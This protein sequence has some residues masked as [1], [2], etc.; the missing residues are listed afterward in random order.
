MAPRG[1]LVVGVDCSTTACKAILWNERGRALAEGRAPVAL[2]NPAPDAYEQDAEA[3]W[4]ATRLAL[5]RAL[6]AAGPRAPSRLDAICVTHQRE[7]VVVT[8]DEGRPLAPALVWMDARC[9]PQVRR[10]REALGED[11]LHQVSGKVPCTTPS[12]YKLMGL[13]ER[14]PSLDPARLRALEVHAFLAYRLTG[15]LATS[16]ASADPTGLVD[17]RRGAW[18]EGIARLAGLDPSRL[19]EL[20]PPGALLGP[21]QPRAARALGLPE[22]LPVVAGAGDGQAAALGAG[23][24]GPE[25]A[26]LNLGTA[27]V[28]GV[29]SPSY[30]V[31]RAFRTLYTAHPGAYLLETDLKGGTFSLGWFAGNVLGRRG[32]RTLERLRALEREARAQPPA[33]GGLLFVPYLHGVMNPYWDDDASALWFGLR[34][35]HDA[36]SLYRSLL[37]GLAFEQRLALE[38][39]EKETGQGV[40]EL[41]VMGGGTKSELFCQIV[42]D[43]TQKPLRLT[44]SAEATCLGAGMLAAVAAGWFGGAAEAARAMSSSGRVVTPG[45][46][47][48]AYDA[49]FRRVYA[50]LYPALERAAAEAAK[51]RTPD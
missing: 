4:R 50:G 9:R 19:P 38:G 36:A 23:V 15:R 21:L 28:C 32:A 14:E 31:G 17:M 8:D 20:V 44:G 37:E 25:S 7:T 13:F 29:P 47:R 24:T 22:G 35:D 45:P 41:R 48:S 33:S 6:A 30:R 18:A 12:V 16:L 11:E 5:R 2:S 42:A 43:V 34:G 51:L 3:W 46:A 1:R 26:Y 40:G 39:V 27:L 49:W 10:A